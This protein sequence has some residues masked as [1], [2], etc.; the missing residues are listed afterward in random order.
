MNS[1]AIGQVRL[2]NTCG[3]KGKFPY[4]KILLIR[5]NIIK[6]TFSDHFQSLPLKPEHAQLAHEIF[7]ETRI[8]IT[9]EVKRHLGAVIG[10][11]GYKEQ[12]INEKIDSWYDQL[13]HLSKIAL[14]EPHAAYT[15]F[16]GGFRHKLTYVMRSISGISHLFEKIDEIV[17]TEFIPALTGEI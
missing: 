1:P 13:K 16:V 5:Q 17:S 15:A 6:Q 10:S 3:A 12:Y 14:I 11:N 7:Q 9:T 8:N 4:T 2:Y